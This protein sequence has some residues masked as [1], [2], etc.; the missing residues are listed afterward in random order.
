MEKSKSLFVCF[1]F[2]SGMLFFSTLVVAL[3]FGSTQKHIY[4]CVITHQD[5]RISPVI[6]CLIM[7]K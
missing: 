7:K 5:L 3:W 1:F 6:S 4:L 2:K